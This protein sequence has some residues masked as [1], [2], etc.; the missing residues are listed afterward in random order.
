MRALICATT[1]VQ[2]SLWMSNNRAM[3]MHTSLHQLIEFAPSVFAPHSVSMSI[4]NCDDS[5]W[6]A[7]ASNLFESSLTPDNQSIYENIICAECSQAL[8]EFTQFSVTLRH[9]ETAC[10][11]FIIQ[12]CLSSMSTY[13]YSNILNKSIFIHIVSVIGFCA[14]D[15]VTAVNNHGR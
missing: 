7:V 10:I 5:S 1:T 2:Y 11:V 12:I 13:I 8:R 6:I 4:A 15:N 9:A 3:L 14:P